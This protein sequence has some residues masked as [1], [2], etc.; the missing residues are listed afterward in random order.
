MNRDGLPC[1]DLIQIS[2]PNSTSQN[3]Y[4]LLVMAFM[5]SSRMP[6]PPKESY[7][8]PNLVHGVG[9]GTGSLFYEVFRGIGGIVYDPYKGCCENGFKGLSI[10]FFKGIGGLIGRPIKGGFD[11]VA[12][13]IVGAIKT[14]HF[15]YK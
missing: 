14:P 10:G 8:A 7:W 15:I 6:F 3:Q 11:F 4:N 9:R 1:G 12:Q 2:V 5:R 13:P